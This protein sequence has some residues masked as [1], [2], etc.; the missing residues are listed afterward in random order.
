MLLNSLWELDDLSFKLGSSVIIFFSAIIG[1]YLP[2]LIGSYMERSIPILTAFAGGICLSVGMCHLLVDSSKILR[3]TVGEQ[4]PF[5]ANLLCVL[6]FTILLVIEQ[7]ADSLQARSSKILPIIESHDSSRSEID[8][9]ERQIFATSAANI[10]C[11]GFH[12]YEYNQPLDPYT[13]IPSE[14]LPTAA[15]SVAPCAPPNV[16]L[17]SPS[18]PPAAH[19]SLPT[20]DRDLLSNPLESGV[21]GDLHIPRSHT[22]TP[23]SAKSTSSPFFLKRNFLQNIFGGRKS[24]SKDF[25]YIRLDE[26]APLKTPPPMHKV[27]HTPPAHAPGC[28]HDH[29]S[30]SH[31]PHPDFPMVKVCCPGGSLHSNI[32]H[33]SPVAVADLQDSHN[34]TSK[35]SSSQNKEKQTSIID[36]K[37]VHT[38]LDVSGLNIEQ[39]ELSPNIMIPPANSSSN[40]K[41]LH[42]T[43]S[44]TSFQQQ[45]FTLEH[46]PNMKLKDVLSPSPNAHN[47][48]HNSPHTPSHHHNNAHSDNELGGAHDHGAE[49]IIKQTSPALAVTLF[50][51]FAAHSTMEGLGLGVSAGSSM[52]T[53]AGAIL[54]HKILEGFALGTTLSQSASP[55]VLLIYA[56]LFSLM[57]PIGIVFGAWISNGAG[58]V[59]TKGVLSGISMGIASGTFAYV[60]FYEVIPRAFRQ[61]SGDRWIKVAA[62]VLGVL[63][64]VWNKILKII[65]ETVPATPV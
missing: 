30:H 45:N 8:G 53:V 57:T 51:A 62:M 39:Q 58:A 32:P 61:G 31:H 49:A 22:V 20:D 11:Q 25:D 44:V 55:R 6:G 40:L 26:N 24:E 41:A 21:A 60:S 33:Q 46:T 1:V 10:C 5:I 23:V 7:L 65:L 63:V 36:R 12:P 48:A 29:A 37:V 47:Q 42:Q 13:Y 59:S 64:I 43:P 3:S 14:F 16:I 18:A 50:A 27:S 9:S 15:H 34:R 4:S 54:G 19:H 35:L 56:C 17:R 38:N 52:H 2:K 28:K